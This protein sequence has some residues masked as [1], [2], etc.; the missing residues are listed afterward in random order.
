MNIGYKIK[1]LREE[2]GMTQIE[3]ANRIG[4]SRQTVYRWERGDN[5]PDM[6]LLK[7]VAGVFNVSAD[8]LLS[9]N[10][11]NADTND[12]SPDTAAS[13]VKEQ[14]CSEEEKSRKNTKIFLLI[15]YPSAF[16][17][18][19]L[20]IFLSNATYNAGFTV[21]FIIVATV[22]VMVTIYAL[23]ISPIAPRSMISGLK[24]FIKTTLKK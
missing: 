24:K 17:V 23:F 15:F 16:I 19:G 9:E 2:K 3:F 1:K 18:L 21:L 20:F 4:V 8:Y 7:S 12:Y 22:I 14:K 6:T 5:I 10:D 11:Y 13:D